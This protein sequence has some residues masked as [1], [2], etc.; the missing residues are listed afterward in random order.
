MVS[1]IAEEIASQPSVWHR[2]ADVAAGSGLAL[3]RPGER[4]LA[5][6]C[7]TSWFV[8]QAYAALREDAGDGET[9]AATATELTPGRPYD[10]AVVISRSGTTTEVIDVLRDLNA[11]DVPSTAITA[12]LGSP[13]ATLASRAL[14]LDFA[15]ERSVVQTRFATGAL[16]L[17]RAHVG[18]DLDRAIVD[19]GT[20]LAEPLPVDPAAFDHFVLLGHRWTIGLAHEGALKLREAAQA[21]SESYPAMEYRHGPISVAGPTSLVMILGTPDPTI[22]DDVRACG[23][24]VL[25]AELDPMAELLRIQRIAVALAESRGLD[26]DHPRHL[27]RSVVLQQEGTG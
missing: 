25:V 20:A 16:A 18:E 11:R 27:T 2:A 21:H 1:D 9:D 6:G 17:L 19:A 5:V 8:A 23:A 10:R 15:D 4:V 12:V 7:G 24:T 22:A 14:I 3:P 13:V 26:P